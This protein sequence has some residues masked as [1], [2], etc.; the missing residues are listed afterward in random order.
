MFLK[1]FLNFDDTKN[2]TNKY[3]HSDGHNLLKTYRTSIKV[4]MNSN[5]GPCKY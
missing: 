3:I 2:V 4:K 5:D 1:M